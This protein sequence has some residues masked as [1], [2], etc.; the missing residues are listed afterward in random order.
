[1]GETAEAKKMSSSQRNREHKKKTQ[2]AM[3]QH[4]QQMAP[5]KRR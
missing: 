1:M 3:M 4:L 5:K 2:K